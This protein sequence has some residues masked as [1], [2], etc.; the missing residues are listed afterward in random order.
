MQNY[1]QIG[2]IEV[3]TLHNMLLNKTNLAHNFSKK[4]DGN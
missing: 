3:Y 4:G 2:D 1:A